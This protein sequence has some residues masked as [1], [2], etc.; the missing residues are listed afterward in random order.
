M[1]RPS[2]PCLPLVGLWLLS[3]AVGRAAEPIVA[4]S[5]IT[6]VAVYADR[7]V[8]TRTAHVDLPAGSQVVLF[9]N[10]PAS[11][12][13]DLLQVAAEGDAEVTILEVRAVPAQLEGPADARLRA[14]QT[15]LREIQAELRALDDRAA[16]VQAHRDFLERIKVAATT[17]GDREG[18]ALPSVAQWEQLT[19]FYVGELAKVGPQAQEIERLREQ[20]RARAGAV[21]REIAALQPGRDEAVQDVSVRF[22]VT[23]PGELDLTL[24]YTVASASWSPVYDVRVSSGANTLSLGYAAMV[25]QASG[26]DWHG[27]KLTLSTARPEIGGTPPELTPW[28]VREARARYAGKETAGAGM[29]QEAAKAAPD[30]AR[31]ERER[32]G[33]ARFADAAVETGL[34]A[35]TFVVEHAADVPADNAPHKVPIAVIPLDTTLTHLAIPKLVE[36]AY[37]RAAVEN[38][39]AYPLMAGPVNL[40]VDGTFVA[41]TALRTVM[42]GE[43]FDLDLGVDDAVTVKRTLVNRFTENTGLVSRKQRITYDVTIAVQNNR[44]NAIHLFVKDQLPVSQHERISVQLLEPP[45]REVK[46]ED[47]GTLTWEFDLAP[48]AA[49]EL[50]LRI[51]VEHPTEL[52][53]DGLEQ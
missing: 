11:V 33:A 9:R 21:E 41:R 53:I 25:R 51:S 22:D 31:K 23:Q 46:R 19:H 35:A 47:D 18:A 14:L 1:H 8:V 36:H 7:A 50:P 6:A 15:Q 49:R 38:T 2:P 24:D 32:R 17:V 3:A 44:A 45:A 30:E 39:S 48:G 12:D 20:V 40:F 42:P 27:A 5:T 29:E 10:L 28:Y 37:L 34:T 52:A 4:D 13:P 43:K 16:V 26:E